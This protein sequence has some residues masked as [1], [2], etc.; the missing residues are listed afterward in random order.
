M[1]NFNITE[2]EINQYNNAKPFPHIV[3][4]D[5]L[6]ESILENVLNEFKDF[7]QWGYDNSNYSKDHQVNKFFAPW[8]KSGLTTLPTTTK[9][10]LEY[11]NS[12][13]FLKILENLT[14]ISDLIPD[15]KFIGGGC[16]K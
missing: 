5:F 10:V 16:T 11:F 7:K 8:D 9:T 15:D 3:I 6:Q 13:E 4:N 12:P 1:V 14:G 2:N